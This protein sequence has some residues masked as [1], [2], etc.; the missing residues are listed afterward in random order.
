[1]IVTWKDVL[2]S[3]VDINNDEFPTVFSPANIDLD[4]E[5]AVPVKRPFTAWSQRRVYF[6]VANSDDCTIES[7][8][9]NPN[10]EVVLIEVE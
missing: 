5:I 9:R 4:Q 2:E 7:V 8:P 1:M 6:I 10:N 3:E